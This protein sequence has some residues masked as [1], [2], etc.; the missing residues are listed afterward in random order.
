MILKVRDFPSVVPADFGAAVREAIL[1][2]CLA[3][4]PVMERSIDVGAREVTA[5]I[6][7]GAVDAHRT[8]LGARAF[9]RSIPKFMERPTCLPE[10]QRKLAN[11][12]APVVGSAR[13][14]WAEGDKLLART[15]FATTAV[16]NDRWEA[17]KDGHMR[18]FSVGFKDLRWTR[19][20]GGV[21]RL[22]EGELREY[23]TVPVPSNDDALVVRYVA[24]QLDRLAAENSDAG[25]AREM[26]ACTRELRDLVQRVEDALG[27][28]QALA[29]TLVTRDAADV[30]RDAN[31][32]T[33]ELSPALSERLLSIAGAARN[34][35]C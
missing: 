1:A 24:G 15:A 9:A 35:R 18:A 12:M 31:D 11:G 30:E 20:A 7:S 21:E 25:Q 19:E 3:T 13:R 33:Y 10:H 22:V 32:D 34:A 26:G 16:G 8:I 28:M 2:D 17:Y 14:I 6:T 4:C 5:V 23:S 27:Q 29:D